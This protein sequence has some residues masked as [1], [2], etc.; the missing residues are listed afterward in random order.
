MSFDSLG[1]Y[2]MQF[3]D[4]RNGMSSKVSHAEIISE[5]FVCAKIQP[6]GIYR[7]RRVIGLPFVHLF[8]LISLFFPYFSLLLSSKKGG[9]ALVRPLYC[10]YQ[11]RGFSKVYHR[12]PL[13][14]LSSLPSSPLSK[15]QRVPNP[16]SSTKQ[17]YRFRMN[18]LNVSGSMVCT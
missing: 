8:Q 12:L 1:K 13:P 6:T 2:R 3:L 11:D 17:S 10:Y 5:P 15:G 9:L 18:S 4:C 16:S 14:I 7:A